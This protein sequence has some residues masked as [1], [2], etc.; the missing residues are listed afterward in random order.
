MTSKSFEKLEMLCEANLTQAIAASVYEQTQIHGHTLRVSEPLKPVF[1][2]QII[3]HFMVHNAAL[4][5]AKNTKSLKDFTMKN[6]SGNLH[7]VAKSRVDP[8][9]ETFN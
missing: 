9:E 6:V 5:R 1:N 8:E 2:A 3:N 4:E 7:Y